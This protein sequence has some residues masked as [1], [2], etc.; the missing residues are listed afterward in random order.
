MV[1]FGRRAPTRIK[2]TES[3]P[4]INWRVS[5][6]RSREVAEEVRLGGSGISETEVLQEVFLGSAGTQR[7]EWVD[8]HSSGCPAA[9]TAVHQGLR[10]RHRGFLEER[11]TAK[12]ATRSDASSGLGQHHALEEEVLEV[13]PLQSPRRRRPHGRRRGSQPAHPGSRRSGQGSSERSGRR[14]SADT[15]IPGRG[16]TRH[17]GQLWKVEC[18][19]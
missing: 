4:W 6:N 18:G 1:R 2:S 19:C 17:G 13:V 16:T 5:T 14:G 10:G 8:R 12:T 7:F 9:A 15:S 11:V 3:A